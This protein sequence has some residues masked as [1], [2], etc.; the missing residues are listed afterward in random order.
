MRHDRQ[1]ERA[2][3]ERALKKGGRGP[4]PATLCVRAFSRESLDPPPGTGREPTSQVPT[5]ASPNPDH[6]PG[7][8]RCCVPSGGGASE[9]TLGRSAPGAPPARRGSPFLPRNGEKEGR[10]Q[11]P[12]TPS[13]MAR[14]LPLARFGVC[15][16]LSRSWGYFAAHLR[17]LIWRLSFIKCFS[18]YFSGKCVPNRF[19]HT[20]GNSRTT[21]P[22]P[23]IPKTSEWERAAIKAGSRG[24][25]LVFFPPTFFKESR[26]PPP[27]SAAPPGRCAPRHR[28]S[29]DHPKGTQYPTAPPARSR[30][31]NHA[32][33]P[34]LQRS[35][36]NRLPM[37]E[38]PRPCLSAGQ[39]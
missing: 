2:S 35:Q 30:A 32:A 33:G 4:P 6:L 38:G 7:A 37:T 28:K 21:V 8:A 16:T 13:F 14:L 27:E 25:P 3:S 23:T 10:G 22:E 15:A 19:W 20:G 39:M 29:P 11:A 34:T 17:T 24:L 31:G 9:A 1:N 36:R 26:A 18:A 12:W 5:C